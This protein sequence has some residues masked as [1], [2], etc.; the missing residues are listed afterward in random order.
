MV[1]NKPRALLEKIIPRRFSRLLLA[2]AVFHVVLVLT[3]SLIGR[4]RIMP[5]SFDESGIGISFAVDS[6]AYRYETEKMA[7]IIQEGRFRDWWNHVP[8][9][10]ALSHLRPY[11]IA[12]ALLGKF[13]GYG[14]LAAEPV[15]LFYY[16][17]ILALTFAIGATVFDR[18]VGRYAAAVVGLWPSL[19]LYTTQLL[20]DPLAIAATLLLVFGLTLCIK[21][22]LSITQAAVVAAIACIA[23]FLLWQ[24]RA[25]SWELVWLLL[26]LAAVFCALSQLRDRR[27]G[28]GKILA[29]IAILMFAFWL[30]RVLPAFRLTELA[31]QDAQIRS[32]EPGSTVATVREETN[33]SSA[34]WEKLFQNVGYLRHRFIERYPDAGSNIDAGVELHNTGEVLRYF[35]RAVEIGFLAPFPNMWLARGAQVGNSGRLLVGAEMLG[36]YLIIVLLV[37]TLIHLWNSLMV[38]FLFAAAASG[39]MALAY[40]VINISSLYRMRYPFFIL[41][42]IL[43]MKGWFI[44]R[45][46][47]SAKQPT[48]LHG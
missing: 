34:P 28:T 6:A 4:T 19:L 48:E 38:W 10:R 13:F 39:C 18:N 16:L 31:E 5:G 36:M 24:G 23:L 29:T 3:I 26:L 27:L 25:D 1:K 20:R 42:I 21:R 32:V 43:G 15:N 44:A 45:E 12:F 33:Q 11:S 46:R 37:I 30:P 17:A 35:P 47:L 22:A 8:R 40:V 14:I 9:Y 2:A 7:G 41:L